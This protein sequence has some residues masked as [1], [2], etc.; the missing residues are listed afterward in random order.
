[1]TKLSDSHIDAIGYRADMGGPNEGERNAAIDRVRDADE[2]NQDRLED[3]PA[4]GVL[5][6]NDP[7]PPEPS[8]PG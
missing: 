5:D 2:R 4:K 8:E 3:A 6:E 1:M 7:D